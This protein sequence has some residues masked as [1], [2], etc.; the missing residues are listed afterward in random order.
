MYMKGRFDPGG[1]PSLREFVTEVARDLPGTITEVPDARALPWK[2]LGSGADFVPFQDHLGVPSLSIEFIGANG[3]GFG[4]YHSNYDSR[5][6]VEQVADPGFK[7][8]VAMVRV[9]GT[10]AL[11]M[12]NAEVLPFRFA[13]YAERLRQGLGELGGAVNDARIPV[14]VGAWF[15]RVTEIAIVAANL[16]AAIDRRLASAAAPGSFAALNDRLARLEQALT[17][18]DGAPASRWY[19]HVFYG[20]NIYSLYDGQL[21]PGLAEA[22]RLRDRARV[23]NESARITRALDRMHAELTAALA[24]VR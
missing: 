14:D 21:F 4:T 9:L 16:E 24:S 2:S 10:L 19:R 17:D 3:Y 7:Q 23:Q 18:D 13:D 15:A 22:L 8:G 20:W 1:V 12:S 5:A 11:R 6:Y